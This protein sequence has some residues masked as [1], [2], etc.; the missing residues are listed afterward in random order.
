[1]ERQVA[2]KTSADGVVKRNM[3]TTQVIA[4][5]PTASQEAIKTL[6]TNGGGFFNSGVYGTAKSHALPKTDVPI[7]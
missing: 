3:A 2:E 7:G 4:Q 1:M 5:G 6:G